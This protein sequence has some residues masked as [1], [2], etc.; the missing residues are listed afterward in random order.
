LP[1]KFLF[2]AVLALVFLSAA[3]QVVVV[4][5]ASMERTVLIGDHLLVNRMAFWFERVHRGDVV[6]F[7]PPGRNTKDVYL[8]RVVAV[9]G[10]RVE[11]R[12]GVVYV[13]EQR[14]SEPY[15]EHVY[16]AAAT[17]RT[18]ITVPAG[19]LFVLGDNRDRSED[20]RCF[21][22]VPV[23]NVVGKPV[24]VLWSFAIPTERWMSSSP[25]AL[26]MDHPLAHLRWTRFFHSLQ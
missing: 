13:N 6:S 10:D 17:I 18:R 16:G 25:A 24:L 3:F 5:T 23:L 9:S 22:T 20:S 7:H 8:K 2:V 1:R 11:I 21:G 15:V 14:A 4:P 12:D 19:E 26:Y